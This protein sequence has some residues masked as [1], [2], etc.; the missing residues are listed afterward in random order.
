MGG[1]E[2]LRRYLEGVWD[3]VLRNFGREDFLAFLAARY[4]RPLPLDLILPHVEL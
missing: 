1:L 4:R 3:D 2:E